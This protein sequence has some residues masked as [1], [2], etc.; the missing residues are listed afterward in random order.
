MKKILILLVCLLLTGCNVTYNVNI[1]DELKI[2]EEA[3]IRGDEELYSA[4]FRTSRN[5]VLN[6]FLDIYGDTLRENNYEYNLIKGENPYVNLK[7][8][9]NN[10]NE[11]LNSSKL[12]NGYFDRIDYKVDGNKIKIETIGFHYNIADDPE[13]FYV[14]NVD[15]AINL[16]FKVINHNATMVDENTN[17]Y[18]YN[19]SSKAENFKIMLEFDSS[20][21]FNPNMKTIIKIL[22][23]IGVIIL[24][25]FLV[26]YSNRRKKI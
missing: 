13:R 9:Y 2:T 8:S 6:E 23:L 11:Y 17:T 24:T 5:K 1:T 14:N 3:I 19:L 7:H 18:Y 20:T 21:K 10:I 15:I 26:Y 4:Y 16:P 25:W 22:I 12:F